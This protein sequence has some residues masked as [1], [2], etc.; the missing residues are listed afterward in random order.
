MARTHINMSNAALQQNQ[1]NG[2]VDHGNS[3]PLNNQASGGQP[4]AWQ[5]TAVLVGTVWISVDTSPRYI[6]N[7]VGQAS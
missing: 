7:T 1:A 2:Y 4:P 6:Y 5:A 3:A